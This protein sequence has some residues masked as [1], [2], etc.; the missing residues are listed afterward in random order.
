MNKNL[1][2]GKLKITPLNEYRIKG[3]LKQKPVFGGQ[4]WTQVKIY[5]NGG[6]QVLNVLLLVTFNIH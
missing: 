4:K 1:I 5:P 2:S 3:K 6:V